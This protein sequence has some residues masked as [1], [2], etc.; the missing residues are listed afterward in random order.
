MRSEPL[1]WYARAVHAALA[2]QYRRMLGNLDAAARE[3]LRE[4][5]REDF[6]PRRGRFYWSAA[7]QIHVAARDLFGHLDRKP[8]NLSWRSCA[9][10]II[11]F[12]NARQP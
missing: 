10:M 5:V 8:K 2:A 12:A 3:M 9:Q 1:P 6:E 11:E 4:D 7:A